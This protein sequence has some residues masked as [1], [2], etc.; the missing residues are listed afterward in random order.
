MKQQKLKEKRKRL[1]CSQMKL[2][3]ETGWPEQGLG[4][5]KISMIENDYIKATDDEIQSLQASL[6]K[7]ESKKMG[8]IQ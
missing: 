5:C 6:A 4:R 3:L 1:G 8:G 2:A 7:I